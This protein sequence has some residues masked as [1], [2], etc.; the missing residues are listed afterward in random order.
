MKSISYFKMNDYI[1]LEK[2]MKFIM[3][4]ILNKKV[5]YF[6][7]KGEF[8][9]IISII[10]IALLV[11]ALL[12]K[13]LIMIFG[14]TSFIANNSQ[15]IVGSLVNVVLIITGLNVEGWRKIIL[16]STLPSL[17]AVGSGYVFGSLSA[18]TIYMIPGIWLGNLTLILLIKYLYVNKKI[19]YLI[20]SGIA[21]ITKVSIIFGT[22]NIWMAFSVLPNQGVVAE[23]LRNSMGVIQLITAT[24]GATISIILMK[25]WFEKVK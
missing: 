7:K 18:A 4:E 13:I 24:I 3:E 19:N 1:F 23:T 8:I 15:I 22:L 5:Y 16:I 9:Q 21:I 10:L 20:S 11:P 6:S 12:P 17:S 14:K 2:G 25:T